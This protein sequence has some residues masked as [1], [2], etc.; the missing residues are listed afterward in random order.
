M[1]G[2]IATTM[3]MSD[4]LEFLIEKGE[5]VGNNAMKRKLADLGQLVT[6]FNPVTARKIFY[7]CGCV[8]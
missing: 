8:Y 3:C 2:S 5:L 1:A 4:L 6:E 7:F